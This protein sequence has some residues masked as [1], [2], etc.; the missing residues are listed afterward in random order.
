[1]L[2]EG[3]ESEEPCVGVPESRGV[4]RASMWIRL[5][6]Q[7]TE[8]KKGEDRAPAGVAGVGIQSLRKVRRYP[9]SVETDEVR[10]L[11]AQEQWW[12]E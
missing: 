2:S 3:V 8:P 12:A 6:A 7:D 11:S 9:H 5:P 4:R 1:M 10:R